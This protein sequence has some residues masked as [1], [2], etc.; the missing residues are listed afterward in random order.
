MDRPID[1][2]N[3]K[4]NHIYT[5]I[6]YYIRRE[7]MKNF[8]HKYKKLFQRFWEGYDM[9]TMKLSQN[10]QGGEVCGL[11]PTV[12]CTWYTMATKT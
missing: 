3:D 11:I 4:K 9:G 1:L 8:K 2:S 6:V 10:I 12:Y 7:E 5:N